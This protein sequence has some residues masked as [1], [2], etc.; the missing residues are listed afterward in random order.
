MSP[1]VWLKDPYLQANQRHGEFVPNVRASDAVNC[2][3]LVFLDSRDNEVYYSI[4]K[5]S[6]CQKESEKGPIL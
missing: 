1:I 5:L 2:L 3:S 6:T 4:I